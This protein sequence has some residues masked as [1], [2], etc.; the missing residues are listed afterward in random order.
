MNGPMSRR[1]LLA[2]T[3]RLAKQSCIVLTLPMVLSGCERARQSAAEGALFSTLNS[4]E[5]S[6]LAAIASRILPSDETPGANEAGV[7]HFMDHVL[8][9]GRDDELA[10]LRAGLQELQSV[11]LERFN[12]PLFASLDSSQQDEV[13]TSIEFTQF[14]GTMRFLTIAGMFA[15]PAYG[16]SPDMPGYRLIGFESRHF[17][18]PPF[19]YYDADYAARGE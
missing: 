4:D 10:L 18:Q 2:L 13:L 6:E 11:V 1:A 7:I 14:F 19:G 16:G 8:G 12:T 5:A 3:A 9:D 17:W 15:L